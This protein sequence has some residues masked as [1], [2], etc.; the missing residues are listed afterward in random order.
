MNTNDRIT[1]VKQGK[2]E[3]DP[4][5]GEH[6]EQDAE[7]VIV[8]ANVTDIGMDR[9]VELFGDFGKEVYI[10]RL[11]HIPD[12]QYDYVLYEGKQF[13]VIKE[14]LRTNVLYIERDEYVKG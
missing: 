11:D 8:P 13:K 3:Y 5:I 14:R 10:A 12:F 6:V 4:M 2:P 1:L 7:E 9:S